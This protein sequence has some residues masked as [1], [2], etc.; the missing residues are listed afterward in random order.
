MLFPKKS[1]V[2]ENEY[3]NRQNK[4]NFVSQDEV[5]EYKVKIKKANEDAEKAKKEQKN[6][7]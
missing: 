6:Y 7:L 4:G 2:L 1:K 5:E 3:K